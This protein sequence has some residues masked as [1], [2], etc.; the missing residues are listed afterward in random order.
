MKAERGKRKCAVF[1]HE[2]DISFKEV[3]LLAMAE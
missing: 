1:F 3:L 2:P